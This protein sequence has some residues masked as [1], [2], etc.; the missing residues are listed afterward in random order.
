MESPTEISKAPSTETINLRAGFITTAAFFGALAIVLS[1]AENYIPRPTPFMKYGFANIAVLGALVMGGSVMCLLCAV[2]KIVGTALSTGTLGSPL[3][4]MSI[5]GT[6]LS[7]M[8][9]ICMARFS[10][11]EACL[12]SSNF[13][14]KTWRPSIT[15]I[16]IF[17]A[18][19]HTIGQLA[20]ASVLWE[21]IN[22]T[23]LLGPL[24]IT[25]CITGVLSGI[26]CT[27]ILVRMKKRFQI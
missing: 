4:M 23:R 11:I 3:F 12:S 1:F 16:S 20:G 24:C 10:D 6:A 5:T 14:S 13:F 22:F 9:M 21:N 8:G 17:G 25:S 15:G 7:C 2:L 18:F 26:L 27:M 19:L